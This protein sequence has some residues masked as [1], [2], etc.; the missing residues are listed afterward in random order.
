MLIEIVK[1][2]DWYQGMEGKQYDVYPS[3]SGTCYRSEKYFAV[4][5][6]PMRR[7]IRKEDCRILYSFGEGPHD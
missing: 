6:S 7:L 4:K 1:G 5:E 2:R 3:L